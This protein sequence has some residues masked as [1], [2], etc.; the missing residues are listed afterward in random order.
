MN[1]SN[2]MRTIKERFI[3]YSNLNSMMIVY[4]K[5]HLLWTQNKIG[6]QPNTKTINLNAV[7]LLIQ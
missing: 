3:F 4:F 5:V 7:L 6:Q 1:Q 2:R